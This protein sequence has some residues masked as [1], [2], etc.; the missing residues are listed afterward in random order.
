MTMMNA[1]A[2]PATDPP[3][4]LSE[5]Y[6]VTAASSLR[7]RRYRTLKNG[8]SFGV[9]DHG[10]DIM[11]RPGQHRRAVFP[12]HP[13]PVPA[14][15]DARRR[16]A[17][18]AELDA[19]VGQRHAHI[20]PVQRLQQRPGGDGEGPGPDP[21]AALAVPGRRRLPLPVRGAQLRLR[22]PPRPARPQ[23]R[24]GLRRPVRGARHE[25]AEARRAARPRCRTRPRVTLAY[26]GLDGLERRTVAGVPAR[27]DG[28]AARP[29]GLPPRA[30]A[31]RPGHRVPDR[32]RAA[33]DA[34]AGNPRAAFLGAYVAARRT[35]R[36]ST[37]RTARVSSE[38]R[39]VPAGAAAGPPATCACW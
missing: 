14:G 26:R 39:G 8:D 29:R 4:E 32:V 22:P 12:G 27:A 35:L 20:G 23:L 7:E 15:R 5:A 30:G 1:T 37:A 34:A 10:G 25:P 17:A 13:A 36:A 18:A 11:P 19:R 16:A 28:A 31:A 9:F 3:A 21:R 6:A 24:G 38:R 2:V 33:E